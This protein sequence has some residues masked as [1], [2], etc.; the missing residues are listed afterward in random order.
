M[1]NAA[2]V[3]VATLDADALIEANV[4]GV[5]RTYRAMASAG[6]G[7]AVHTSSATAYAPKRGHFYAEDDPLHPPGARSH[8][9][10][11]YGVSKAAGEHR[12]REICAEA[13]IAWSVC[14]P[15]TVYGN[16]DRGTFTRWFLRFCPRR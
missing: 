5:E 9:L 2:L 1:A 15:H 7:R 8:W 4:L 10:N 14:R 16:H 13:G 6:V 11:H 3:S 12:L